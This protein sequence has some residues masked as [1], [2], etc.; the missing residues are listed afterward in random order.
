MVHETY[1]HPALSRQNRSVVFQV[2]IILLL[3]MQW[4]ELDSAQE[5]GIGSLA[6]A[7]K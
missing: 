1:Q 7:A 6:Q 5:Q 4:V 3:L 2:I